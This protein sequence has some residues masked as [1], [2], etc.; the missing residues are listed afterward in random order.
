V[1]SKQGYK[2]TE[3]AATAHGKCCVH[4]KPCGGKKAG[5]KAGGGGGGGGGAKAGG[6][7]KDK[8]GKGGKAA[9][10]AAS[11]FKKMERKEFKITDIQS[12]DDFFAKAQ[13]PLDSMVELG[14]KVATAYEGLHALFE[15]EDAIAA[16]VTAGDMSALVAHYI[17][18]IKKS[19]VE[20][21]KSRLVTT[22]NPS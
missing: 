13:E 14:E 22:L 3:C 19:M 18:E 11:K 4:A 17:K 10:G 12:F 20:I 1:T 5:K 6:G 9:K 21:S 15:A 16:G 7:G 8:G 2:C